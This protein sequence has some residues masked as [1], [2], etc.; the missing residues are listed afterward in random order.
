MNKF[1]YLFLFLAGI[2]VGYYIDYSEP[3]ELVPVDCKLA[4][5]RAI[6]GCE[7][8]AFQVNAELD[9]CEY[10]LDSIVQNIEKICIET[11]RKQIRDLEH[12][13]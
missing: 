12:T 2:S 1:K 9:D 11:F 6:Q 4:E 7:I 8:A 3:T 13:Y 5:S 10:R